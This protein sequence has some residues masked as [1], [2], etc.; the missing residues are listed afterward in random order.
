MKASVK[1]L[2]LLLMSG[3]TKRE[4]RLLI[5]FGACSVNA[6]FAAESE[7]KLG[8]KGLGLIRSLSIEE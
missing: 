8:G 7:E 3:R 6:A 2:K 4:I 5:G 1:P